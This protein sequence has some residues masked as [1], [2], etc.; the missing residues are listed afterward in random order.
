LGEFDQCLGSVTHQVQHP[1]AKRLEAPVDASVPGVIRAIHGHLF[2][3]QV[4]T[5]KVHEHQHQTLQEGFIHGPD[6]RSYLALG[7]AL[8]FPGCGGVQDDALQ[9]VHHTSQGTGRTSHMLLQME[10]AEKLASISALTPRLRPNTNR[11]ATTKRMS[12][13]RSAAVSQNDDSGER[14]RRLIAWR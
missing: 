14:S 12:Q 7:N 10:T 9:R 2:H 11:V 8:L 13:F 3:Q 1:D 5:G 4:A 6:D